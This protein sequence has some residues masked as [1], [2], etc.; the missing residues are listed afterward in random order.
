MKSFS[1]T[2]L[3]LA[4]GACRAKPLDEPAAD[5]T[6]AWA[7]K[8]TEQGMTPSKGVDAAIKLHAQRA[9]AT[10]SEQQVT[11]VDGA[12]LTALVGAGSPLLVVF[13]APW[14]PHCQTF[15][16]ADE[17]GD[18]E[19][20]PLEILNQRILAANGP[21]VVKFDVQASEAPASFAFEFIPQVFL[22]SRLA[23]IP[24]KG[25]PHDLAALQSFATGNAAGGS[26]ASKP[27]LRQAKKL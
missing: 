22:A 3:L 4:L 23:T 18:P 26:F 12:A 7:C 8:R 27:T 21:K 24:F 13:Y 5:T 15:V 6:P 9:N 16:M 2:L 25:D 11:A 14:C 20:A 17:N 10:T 19:K 1:L